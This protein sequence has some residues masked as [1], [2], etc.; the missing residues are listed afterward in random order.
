MAESVVKVPLN[1]HLCRNTFLL[2]VFKSINT[3]SWF[4]SG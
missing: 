1:S 4:T 3:G 2:A